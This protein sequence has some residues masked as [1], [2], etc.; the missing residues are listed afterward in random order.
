MVLVKTPKSPLDSKEIKPVNLKGDQPWILIGMTD[1]EAETPVLWSFYVNS[2]LVG[3]VPGADGGQKEK[4]SDEIAE[5]HHQYNGR[6]LGQISGDGEG[7][8]GLAC[9][10]LWGCKELGKTRWLNNN[11]SN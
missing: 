6:E 9:C 4:A 1:A 3:K 5:W 10:S 8:R 7:Q 11:N 2:W